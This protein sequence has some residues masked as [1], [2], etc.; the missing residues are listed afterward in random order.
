MNLNKNNRLRLD[1]DFYTFGYS[2]VHFKPEN[3]C[4]KGI[5]PH[6]HFIVFLIALIIFC[7]FFSIPPFTLPYIQDREAD[8]LLRLRG[9]RTADSCLF[10]IYLDES[11]IQTLGGWPI[12]RDYYSYII[13]ILTE[14][15]A[16][17]I[18]LDI[19]L[20]TPNSQ[21]PEFDRMLAEFLE[22]S[23]RVVLPNVIQT[24]E[25]MNG[26][27]ELNPLTE[28]VR[29][30]A[31]IGFSNL[32]ESAVLRRIPVITGDS[33]KPSFGLAMAKQMLQGK[34][35]REKRSI[36]IDMRDRSF[37]QIPLDHG[38]IWMNPAGCIQQFSSMRFTEVL[39]AYRYQPGS[40][41]FSGKLVLIAAIAPSLPV[42]RSTSLC[43]QIPASLIHGTVAENII[44]QN[45]L[46]SPRFPMR[47]IW[48]LLWMLGTVCATRFGG[49]KALLWLAVIIPAMVICAWA[50]ICYFYTVLPITGSL[51][52]ILISCLGFIMYQ[53]RHDKQRHVSRL[54]DIEAQIQRKEAEMALAIKRLSETE[55]RL[56]KELE[57]KKQ[58]SRETRT[59][60]EQKEA[61]V[62]VLEKQVRDL[63][64]STVPVSQELSPKY[65]EII[66][67]PESPLKE[68]LALVAK[69]AGDD[70]PVLIQGETGTGKE[71]IA[72]IIHQSSRRE[73]KAF[74]AV[75]C[76]AL[77]ESLLES[78]LF[79]HE[80]GAFTG[81]VGQ[82]RGRFEL[83]Q[84]GTL[85]L[86]EITETTLHF[87]AR[88]LRVLQEGS[89]ERVGGERTLHAD[90]R[91]IAAHN[92]KLSEEVKSGRFRED[93]FFRLTAFP[94]D[95]PPLRD[96]AED[97]PL[98]TGFFIRR[99][100]KSNKIQFSE[101]AMHQLQAYRWPGNVRELENIVRRAAILAK[102]EKRDLIQVKDLPDEIQ[103]DAL[104]Q[105]PA[106]YHPLESQVLETLRA[107]R[108]SHSAIGQTARALGNRDRGTIREY[109]RGL[110]FQFF[111]EHDQ[112]PSKAAAALADSDDQTVNDRIERKIREY[113]E[114]V[115]QSVLESQDESICYKGLPKKFHPYLDKIIRNL[116]E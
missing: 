22:S 114:N 106:L 55:S 101:A 43:A 75:N 91:I 64:G 96:R 84:G 1:L 104:D 49:Q 65:D 78:E 20:D 100:Q 34:I 6:R 79:G 19:W 80:R 72:R 8:L 103:K 36:V 102:S 47:L 7:L 108:F 4:G 44:D 30:A 35:R 16:E 89:F 61:E 95:L 39:N 81:A 11:D 51:A 13:H 93:L 33:L 26:F 29:S 17:A 105:L 70:I 110:C 77:S 5:M 31:A 92:K 57:E 27:E 21:Y 24:H 54:T 98:L 23:G 60:L 86:D 37:L 50:G 66:C 25:M 107:F 45:W 76:G 73:R 62:L 38:R 97:I 113:I 58:L 112:D 69:V 41:N 59:L 56:F 71:M 10:F 99:Y 87:Q 28:F 12:T 88:L 42:L 82:R 85:F 63:R 111:I 83:A 9:S 48:L 32:G 40:L 15:N 74:V 14:K 109:Y 68:T 53:N 67:G 3:D 115:R 2:I 46:R 94:I 90:V 52:I 116:K 18:A